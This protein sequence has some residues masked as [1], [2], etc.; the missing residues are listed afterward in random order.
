MSTVDFMPN[1]SPRQSPLLVGGIDLTPLEDGVIAYSYVRFSGKKQA[2]GDSL[3][4]QIEMAEAYCAR[5]R[6]NLN[7]ATYRD[8]GVSA[9]RGKNA[10]VGNLGEFL[11]AIESEAVKPGS[12]LIVE[13]IDRISRQGIDE[14]WD[15]IKKIL[16]AG[17]LLVTLSPER[18]F[19]VSATKSLSK[20]ALEIQLI[21]ERAA[22]ESE[23]KSVR[24]T[25]VNNQRKKLAREVGM[26]ITKSLPAWVVEIGGKR[27]ND[28]VKAAAVKQIYKLAAAGYGASRIIRRLRD[29]GVAPLGRSGQW[30]RGYVRLLLGDRRVLGEHQPMRADGKTDG[31]PIR[32]YYEPVVTEEQW[33]LVQGVLRSRNATDKGRRAAASVAP[34]QVGRL[35]HDGLSVSKI[36][37]Q[38]QISRPR[39]YR[40]LCELGLH[41]KPKD[42]GNRPI[43]LFSGLLC[44][45]RDGQAYYVKENTKQG[46]PYRLLVAA[47]AIEKKTGASF[48][49][50][51]DVFERAILKCLSEIKPQQILKADKGGEDVG[52]LEQELAG[53]AVELEKAKVTL[54]EKG[55]SATLS[56]YISHLEKRHEDVSARKQAAEIKKARPGSASWEEAQSLIDILD[57]AEDRQEILTRLKAEL[58]RIVSSIQVLVT[59]ISQY[60]IAYVQVWFSTEP[61]TYRAYQIFYNW[62]RNR[63]K[64]QRPARWTVLS[65]KIGKPKDRRDVHLWDRGE[66]IRE[67][68]VWERIVREMQLA[69][70]TE[71]L[72]ELLAEGEPID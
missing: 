40:I 53:I 64:V 29:D 20:G 39:V 43:H 70:T 8:L 13:S 14:G 35:Y 63:G 27:L 45:A 44:N 18:E 9:Y 56:D 30:N 72:G 46:R 69:Y 28:P 1:Q 48:G 50:R 36:A 2:K 12:A 11:K 23:R 22:E 67:P 21:L 66:E 60:R 26:T 57:K 68:K 52:K 62:A 49:F 17:I 41:D 58:R 31:E 65:C 6:W 54:Y 32:N 24:G 71:Y 7:T 55:I 47:G 25:A 15:L 4:R 37:A 10:L 3:R 19:D 33:S 34:E 16:K 59:A 51:A 38:L 61:E 42:N 5:R